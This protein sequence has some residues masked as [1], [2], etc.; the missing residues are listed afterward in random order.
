MKKSIHLQGSIRKQE[1]L[2]PVK[3]NILDNTIVSEAINPYADYYGQLPQ[4]AEP[5]SIFFHINKF[6]FL[7]EVLSYVQSS[8]KCLHDT[9]NIASAHIEINHKQF[10][11][12][13]IKRFPD[14]SQI[15]KLQKCMAKQGVEFS[16]KFQF[17]GE[18]S[19]RINKIFH[20]EDLGD[21]FFMD[22]EE[23]HK[24]Y[25]THHLR[26]TSEEYEEKIT[27]IK[28]N[29]ICRLFD[30]VRG[31]LLIDGKVVELVRIFAEGLD[32]KL[33]ECIKKGFK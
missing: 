4:K 28:N 30:A 29:R 16:D 31:D 7:E 21:G 17:N 3:T 13:R 20:L 33:L 1:F 5:N 14:Y 8:E 10:P 18:V 19:M 23:N 26:L 32:L 25:F 24:G 2:V 12:I 11:A 22:L 15:E 6:Y 9:L 27:A